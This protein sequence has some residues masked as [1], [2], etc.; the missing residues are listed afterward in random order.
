[1]LVLSWLDESGEPIHGPKVPTRARLILVYLRCTTLSSSLE[2]LQRAMIGDI[3]HGASRLDKAESELSKCDDIS[4]GGN[5][6]NV[7][8]Y[9]KLRAGVQ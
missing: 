4:T 5:G 1:M 3:D 8:L 2:Y 6:Y 7:D 9:K